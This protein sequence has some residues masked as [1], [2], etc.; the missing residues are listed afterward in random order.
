[1]DGAV[2][3]GLDGGGGDLAGGNVGGPGEDHAREGLGD[4]EAVPGAKLPG[5]LGL[6][7]KQPTQA[8]AGWR[9]GGGLRT[10]GVGQQ[11]GAGF[12]AALLANSVGAQPSAS[13]PG[14]RQPAGA[15]VGC[16]HNQP[17]RAWQLRSWDR[18]LIPKPFS[19]V[20]FTWPAHVPAGQVTT[21]AVQAALD[22][23]VHMASECS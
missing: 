11:G 17:E 1:M 4:E 5:A 15:W 8:P 16:F 10:D 9:G 6:V 13:Q 7:V 12:G 22:R 23:A 3:G 19:R 20:V 18:F 2:E 21:A 14:S